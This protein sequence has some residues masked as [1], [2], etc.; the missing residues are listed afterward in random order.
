M[1]QV[2]VRSRFLSLISIGVIVVSSA[3]SDSR[4]TNRATPSSPENVSTPAPSPLT[5]FARDLQFVRNGQFTYIFVF[6]RKD[7][8]PINKDDA[9]FLRSNAP[10]VVDWVTTEE[11][12]KVI[13]G[14]NFNLEEGGMAQL[15]KRFIVEDY[16]GK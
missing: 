12:K 13:G 11:G 7:G 3:C 16:S 4:P 6:A 9:A 2:I 1:W 15:K 5:G 10:Q 14:T 8:K